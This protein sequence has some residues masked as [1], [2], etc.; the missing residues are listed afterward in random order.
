MPVSFESIPDNLRMPLYWVEVNSEK[1]G[2][3]VVDQRVLLVGNKL[4]TGAT[5]TANVPI[6]IASQQQ[7]D[8]AFGKGSQLSAMFRAFFAN[9]FLQEVWGMPIAETAGVAATGT[10]TIGGDPT[11]GGA[12][13]L[14]I[15]GQHLVVGITAADTPTTIGDAIVTAVTAMSALPVTA[16]NASGTVTLT[17]K[18]KGA[19]GNDIG[20]EI[21]HY[22]SFGAEFT[23]PGVTVT[24]SGS[25]QLSGGTLNPDFA[26]AITALGEQEFEY[27]ALPWNDLSSQTPWSVEYGFTDAGRWGYIRQ[28][29]GHLFSAQRGTYAAL[30]AA[31]TNN[32]S[33]QL[34]I[35]A[36]EA[37][38]PTPVWEWAAA[39]TAKAGRALVNDPARPLQTLALDSVKA[40]TPHTRF[41]MSELNSLALNGFATQQTKVGDT[42]QISRDTTTYRLNRYGNSDDAYELVTTLATL[43]K[44]IRNQRHVITTKFPRHKLADDG[45]RFGA[46]QAVVTP[47]IIKAELV[48]QYRIDE[49]NGLCEN[50]KA[51]KENL[52]VER[53]PNNPNRVNVVYP[54]DL[55]NQLRVFAVLAQFRLQFSRG[56]D[57]EIAA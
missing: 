37:T 12:L 56:L 33:A 15:G 38:S 46:G 55:V 10:I 20:V 36:V 57:T 7:A 45:T 21:N 17:C 29:Y 35:M 28:H 30:L 23:P 6:P 16:V 50:G 26:A 2:L 52:L 18:W 11:E 32:N 22:G 3:P 24:I 14:Y 34:S 27:V 9:N 39:Y 4:T 13:H 47:K 44:L 40:A 31:S 49:F 8:A 53:D 42:P 5:G 41:S 25:G 43:A 54:P 1:A 51:F 19:N 48:A